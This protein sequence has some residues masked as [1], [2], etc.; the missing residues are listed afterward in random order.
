M[1]LKR[2]FLGTH[3]IKPLHIE[4]DGT[5]DRLAAALHGLAHMV[6]RRR[7]LDGQSIRITL[8]VRD[9]GSRR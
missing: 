3:R 1:S 2:F 5:P 6:N 8:T 7:D 9:T 4:L